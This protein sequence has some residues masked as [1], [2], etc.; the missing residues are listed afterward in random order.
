MKVLDRALD[1]FAASLHG[2]AGQLTGDTDALRRSLEG[3]PCA[4]RKSAAPPPR[5]QNLAS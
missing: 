5:S 4:G 1:L 2:L 3:P